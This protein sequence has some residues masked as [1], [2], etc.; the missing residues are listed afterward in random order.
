M[1]TPEPANLLFPSET[2]GQRC[3]F[4]VRRLAVIHRGRLRAPATGAWPISTRRYSRD[5]RSW[6]VDGGGSLRADPP[7]QARDRPNAVVRS[8]ARADSAEC[9]LPGFEHAELY[10][11]RRA[12]MMH[13]AYV[14]DRAEEF[15]AEIHRDACFNFVRGVF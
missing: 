5:D 1:G 9:S 14:I 6:F 3:R 8:V 12:R 11:A 7:S 10:T 2:P 4:E 15:S 13:V